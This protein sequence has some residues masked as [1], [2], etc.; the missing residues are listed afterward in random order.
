V[1]EEPE[2]QAQADAKEQAGNDWK[3]ECGVFAVVND[4]AGKFSQAKRE[5]CTEIKKCAQEDEEAA[6]EEKCAAEF[7]E[8]IHEKH[9]RRNEVEK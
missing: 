1:G 5:F 6:E 3:I 2:E 4:V 7:A 8:R 9:S